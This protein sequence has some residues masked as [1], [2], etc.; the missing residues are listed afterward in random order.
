MAEITRVHPASTP[1]FPVS[2]GGSTETITY[3]EVDYLADAMQNWS[4]DQHYKKYTKQS[5]DLVQYLFRTY[6]LIVILSK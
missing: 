3:L 1:T 5:A 4:Q 6:Y 2:M